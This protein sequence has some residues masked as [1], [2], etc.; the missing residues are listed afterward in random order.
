MADLET[1]AKEEAF[2]A[3]FNAALS[4]L[5]NSEYSGLCA[6][7]DANPGYAIERGYIV[8]ELVYMFATQ[9][10]GGLKPGH[11]QA[12]AAIK[13]NRGN[14]G[15]Y[16]DNI[17]LN[18]VAKITRQRDAAQVVTGHGVTKTSRSKPYYVVEFPDLEGCVTQGSTL[19]DARA[20]ARGALIGY[21]TS[22]ILHG[23]PIPTPNYHP[24]NDG[25]G[26]TAHRVA[27]LFDDLPFRMKQ[28]VQD[29]AAP[30]AGDAPA[31]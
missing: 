12:L 20:N 14:I 28:P 10:D 18:Y 3:N 8:A 29:G 27:L 6:L 4:H 1:R 17:R 24:R 13:R 7:L 16:G 5:Q 22:K 23:D 21:L 26:Y 9:R 15:D 31:P 11:L 30:P 25:K 2:A 19:H